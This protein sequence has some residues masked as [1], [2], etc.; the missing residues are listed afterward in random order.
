MYRDILELTEQLDVL[1]VD[2]D[3]LC[4]EFPFGAEYK[5]DEGDRRVM[6]FDHIEHNIERWFEFL[7]QRLG[8]TEYK[9]YLT[10]K[11]NF[12]EQI[13]VSK[14]YKDLRA[15]RPFH[16][17]NTR[18]WLI[19]KYNAEVVHGME[20]DDILAVQQNVLIREGKT[21]CIVSRDK[22]LMMVQ[23]WHYGWP[24]HNQ[25]EKLCKA[26]KLGTLCLGTA[27]KKTLW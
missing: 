2:G 6:D 22:D 17:Q 11:G 15:R 25:P 23:G 24:V 26:T 20:A 13:A 16:Y 27:K 7:Q 12:R 18:Q 5:D 21:P 14:K 10:G 4:Y 9:V 1:L 8:C 19:H 3:I